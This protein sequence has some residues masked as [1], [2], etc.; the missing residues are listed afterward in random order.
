MEFYDD[1]TTNGSSPNYPAL[2]GGGL[3]PKVVD[4][5]DD[6]SIESNRAGCD[7]VDLVLQNVVE[8]VLNIITTVNLTTQVAIQP[9][10]GP[11]RKLL[12]P[13]KMGSS[14]ASADH[15]GS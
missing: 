11:T 14:S 12:Q 8:D 1:D 2:I 6:I 10:P 7:R 4:D 13:Q 15:D 5:S 3:L 9:I